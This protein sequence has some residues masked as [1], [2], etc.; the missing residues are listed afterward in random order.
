[1]AES[2]EPIAF[3]LPAELA[4]AIRSRAESEGVTVSEVM[5][6]VVHAWFYG[7]APSANEGYYQSRGNAVRIAQML[8]ARALEA[9]PSSEEDAQA[10]LLEHE[11]AR[12]RR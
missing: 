1:M 11:R 7:E 9:M 12:R 6:N 8:L 3:R 4:Q 5:R 10:A 2:S